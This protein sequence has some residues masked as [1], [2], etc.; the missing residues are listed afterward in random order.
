MALIVDDKLVELLNGMITKYGARNTGKRIIDL[1]LTKKFGITSTDLPDTFTFANGLDEIEFYLKDGNYQKAFN[2]AKETAEEMVRE[3]GFGMNLDE[4]FNKIKVKDLKKI[5][6]ESIEDETYFPTLS[7]A[8]DQVNKKAI[9]KGYDEIN[10]DE[11]FQFGMGGI[12]Y[13]ETKRKSFTLTKN[14]VLVPKRMMH[15]SVYRMDSGTYEL[16]CYIA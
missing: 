1:I 14:G 15:V 10:P 3:E 16:T 6:R 12:S 13:G 5:I 7:Q 9:S 4:S 8:L 2:I 11:F